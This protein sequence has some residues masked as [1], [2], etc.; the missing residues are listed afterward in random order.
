[1]IFNARILTVAAKL[2]VLAL[3]CLK[4]V[5]LLVYAVFSSRVCLHC[6]AVKLQTF[7]CGLQN[8]TQRVDNDL[9][10]ILRWTYL[11]IELKVVVL[12][13]RTVISTFLLFYIFFPNN[14][15]KVFYELQRLH[16]GSLILHMWCAFGFV[17][18]FLP[19]STFC[20]D[21]YLFFLYILTIIVWI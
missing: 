5:Q 1:M 14:Y 9:F 18:S 13:D 8:I 11:S 3:T 4:W 19:S 15:F 16:Q 21:F 6:F 7:V 10:F 17:C 12:C 2:K 20:T